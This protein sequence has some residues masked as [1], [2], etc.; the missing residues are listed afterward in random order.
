M[1]K[2]LIPASKWM[3]RT[4]IKIFHRAGK[5]SDV[6]VIPNLNVMYMEVS[7]V[8]WN[9]STCSPALDGVEF[10]S[11]F[12]FDLKDGKEA[13]TFYSR[14]HIEKVKIPEIVDALDSGN[15]AYTRVNNGEKICC[16]DSGDGSCL[17]IKATFRTCDENDKIEEEIGYSSLLDKLDDWQLIL[18]NADEDVDKA[19]KLKVSVVD[20]FDSFGKEGM[21][22][23]DDKPGQR[24][25]GG[26]ITIDNFEANLA[27]LTLIDGA[28][29]LDNNK[30][31]VAENEKIA[32][33][34]RIQFSGNSGKYTLTL[35]KHKSES[36][37]DQDCKQNKAVQWATD[38][39]SDGLDPVDLVTIFA[40]NT[41]LKVYKNWQKKKKEE[42]NKKKNDDKAKEDERAKRQ[43]AIKNWQTA[44]TKLK[45]AAALSGSGGSEKKYSGSVKDKIKAYN[46]ETE[47]NLA[48]QT[49]DKKTPAEKKADRE[50]NKKVAEEKRSQEGDDDRIK[51]KKQSTAAQAAAKSQTNDFKKASSWMEGGMKKFSLALTAAPI[52]IS[53]FI[54][55]CNSEFTTEAEP[56]DAEFA[57][58][59]FGIG[60]E[61]GLSGGKYF[62]S[63][64]SSNDYFQ[65]KFLIDIC[66]CR[67]CCFSCA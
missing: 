45:A 16:G 33:T 27:P 38:F 19:M 20:W 56:G 26:K 5:D 23:K 1:L 36:N 51:D 43:K 13:L 30:D 54:A 46:A 40:K 65:S 31:A 28:E 39:L 58:G 22:T 42:E 57:L 34:N 53:S 50:N 59:F 64:P 41:A 24:G 18:E 47:K 15:D 10:P 2:V 25:E 11:S 29:P 14:F 49:E 66:S 37:S 12:I 32:K 62:S 17:G 21:F 60:V 67:N 6:F 48:K 61:A 52:L 44:G 7:I 3:F 4:H 8:N 9:N 55:G 63:S 35:N